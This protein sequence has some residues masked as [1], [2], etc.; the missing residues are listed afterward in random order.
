MKFCLQSIFTLLL[1]LLTVG[2]ANAGA[3]EAYLFAHMTADDYGGLY[4]SISTDGLNWTP[5]NGG[6]RVHADYRGHPDITKGHDG[7]YYLLGNP[8]SD[9]EPGIRIWASIDLVDWKVEH[10]F[11]ADFSGLDVNPPTS[12]HGAPKM[13]FDNK[14][15]RYV[16]TWHSASEDRVRREGFIDEDYWGSMRTYF[17]E[18]PDLLNWSKPKRLFDFDHATIDVII[19]REGER[20]YAIIKDETHPSFDHPDGKAIRIASAPS[21]TGPWSEASP[22][23]SPNFR[24]APMLIRRPD[25]NG[26]FLYYE[27]YPGVQY[28]MS[29]A[30]TLEG[31]WWH[32]YVKRL[33]IPEGARHGAMIRISKTELDDLVAHF[34]IAGQR[35]WES[36][37]ED[38]AAHARHESA[39]VEADGKFYLL[40][41]R[42][43][44]P[45]DIFDPETGAWSEGKA[46]PFELHHFQAVNLHGLIY[47]VGAMTGKYP[48][49][50]PVGNILIYDP[51]KDE[52]RLGAEIPENRRRG[53]T[54]VVID[55]DRLYVVAGIRDGHRSG[56]VPWL[57]EFNPTTGE[58]TVLPDAPHARDHFH[59]VA[60]EG[61]IYAAGGRRSGSAKPVFAGTVPEV[62]VYDIETG[63]WST[64]SPA[65]N[66]PTQRAGTMAVALDGRLVIMGGES[67][68]Q[69]PA[70]SE[71]EAL[72]PTTL[73]WRKLPLLLGPRHGA[74]ATVHRGD[75]FIAGGNATRG[76]GNELVALEKYSLQVN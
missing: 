48:G 15:G 47:I 18:S 46:P 32:Y 3:P 54:G 76:G 23:V 1:A 65:S 72:D 39:F 10:E 55:E 37:A 20:Y 73:K 41:G 36:V 19:R 50:T 42:R 51:A 24:E 26:W 63:E 38:G 29:T 59:A 49:E 69:R 35:A 6:G 70:H 75:I 58:W 25:D 34:G 64:L 60:I 66:I 8:P 27:Q 56:W 62:D 57:D 61:Q 7:R 43:I 17:I 45:V 71:V 30:E 14:S 40:G 16:L 44:Q 5:L 31:P 74:Q 4:Y 22:R 53:A 11:I 52:W 21:V 2:P 9:E 28:G 12:W 67:G 33:G 68:K 13:F